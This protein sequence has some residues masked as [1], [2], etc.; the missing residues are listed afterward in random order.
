MTRTE[1][2]AARWSAVDD[3]QLQDAAGGAGPRRGRDGLGRRR[4]RVHR[5][6]RRHRDD[7]PRPRPPEG[8]RGDHRAGGARSGTSPTW[9]C[10]SPACRSPSGCSSWPA[11]RA[12]SSSATPAPRPT[13]RRSRS[14]GCT[15]RPEVVAA[16]GSFH[17][18]TMGA[19]ALT[20][21]PGE[22]RRLRAAA[23]R[24]PLRALRRRRRARR[25]GRRS[26]PRW[27][28]SSR[29]SARAACVPG[30]GRLPGRRAPA[31][32]ADA[33]ALFAAR[34]GADRHRPH[35]RLVRAPGRRP[36]ARPHHPGQ[37]ARRRPA[38]RRD[39]RL[40]RRRR[41]ADG[42]QPRLDLRRQPGRRA[43]ALAV[44]DTIRDEGLLERA[45]ELEHR[46]TAGIEALGHPRRRRR[47]R[48][49]G[50]LLGVVL[51]A[52]VAGAAGGARCATPAS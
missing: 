28:C 12:G 11:A 32:A 10:T 41:P 5:P 8:R 6:A 2:L 21:Q 51:T 46:F 31:T 16:E 17:G 22:G 37:G 14:A 43:A 4:P 25:R 1:E 44:L 49:R 42:G 23:R 7:D 27:C 15:G 34:R 38:D 9:P 18:R 52:D 35:R 29:C 40:R 30:A 36:A 50:A 26:R 48:A 47:P 24:R 20:G 3:D 33:G 45:K 39:A 19:L 13:R